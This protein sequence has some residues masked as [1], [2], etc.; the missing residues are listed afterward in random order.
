M[1]AGLLTDER[2]RPTVAD[3]RRRGAAAS[4]V[5]ATWPPRAD[6]DGYNFYGPTECTVDALAVPGRRRRTG[7]RSGG[8]C[9]TCGPTCSTPGCGRCR[10]GVP[11]ELYLAGARSARGYLHRPGLTAERFVADPFGAGREPD[12]PHRRPGAVDRPTGAL[13]FL[14]RADD[15]VKIRG[16]RIEPG[17][18]E[19]AL[20]AHPEVGRGRRGRPRRTGP[21]PSGWS[22]TSCRRRR[23]GLDAA[24]RCGRWLARPLPDYMVPVRV[25][26]AGR[27]AADPERQARPPGA[28]GAGVRPQPTAAYVAPRTDAERA[29]AGIW[30]EVLGVE[31]VGVEDNF[32]EL[33]GDSILSIQVVSRA[34]QAGLRLTPRDLFRHQTVAALARGRWPAAG[35][36]RRPS[37]GRSPG[38]CR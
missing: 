6:T 33:G 37:R 7:R 10:S 21:A 18:I 32:F 28:A 1:P 29:L 9:A 23:G 11:G 20:A 25:R 12:V 22:P 24:R 4:A 15:Q 31:R 36:R 2:H 35:P 19:A 5:A 30:A 27:A 26:G 13:E 17:E 8:R 38:R 16:F 3:G 34:R 14:G